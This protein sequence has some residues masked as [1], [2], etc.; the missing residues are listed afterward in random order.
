MT[1]PCE[2]QLVHNNKAFCDEVASQILKE[3]KRLELKYNYFDSNSFLSKINSRVE[4]RLDIESKELLK[5]KEM[6]R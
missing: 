3:S 2:L 4:N 6:Y 1:T 5:I